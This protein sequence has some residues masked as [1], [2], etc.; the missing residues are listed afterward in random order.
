MDMKK[1]LQAMDG[2]ASKPVEGAD[3]MARFLRMVK[4]AEINQ[5]AAPAP[6][7]PAPQVKV[8]EIPQLPAQDGDQGNGEVVKTNA[9]GTRTYAG[10][11]GTFTYDAQGKAIKYSTPN[12]AGVGQTVDLTNNQTTQNY[13]AGPL[14]TT[15]TTDANG[16]VVSHNTEYDLG[17]GK[18]AMGQDAKGI[19]SK[20][21][22]GRGEEANNIVSNKDLYAMGNKDKEA[23]Y[24][25]AMAQ[26]NGTPVQENSLSK[27]LS[28]VDKNNVSI[29]KEGTNPHKV[30]LPVQM[31]MQHYQQHTEKP[32]PRER[33]IDKYFVEAETEITQ[34]KEEKRALINQYAKT[35]AERVLMK[36]SAQSVSEAPIEMTGDANDPHI[37]GHEKANP[38]SLKGRIMSARAQL[39]ELAELS[40]SDSLLAW[41]Q[42]CK[43][44]KGGMFMGLEQNL[45]QIRHGIEQLAA[46]RKKG[47]VGS[48]GIDRNIGEQGK[49]QFKSAEDNF[50]T[51]TQAPNGTFTIT[52]H[53]PD[54]TLTGTPRQD[55][56]P[57]PHTGIPTYQ[58][59]YDFRKQDFDLATQFYTMPPS[60]KVYD[61][62]IGEG[63][64][65]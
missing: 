20:S 38:M 44:A 27:F 65:K 15:Q 32:Q 31:A 54:I 30:A 10:G 33:L 50:A 19:T 39:Q 58:K 48:R 29:L 6:A 35:I 46:K 4:E 62:N 55:E 26:V 57:Q 40:E 61:E 59:A 45:E 47:G 22:Q 53:D 3:S 11:F 23:T 64:R 49:E 60:I 28:I 37:Y 8:P 43:K 21:W 25:R 56:I 1:I 9:D 17:L 51:I 63:K 52:Y 34:R 18:M 14:N 36:E 7:K 16:N 5:P 2:V 13:N 41:E 42:I 12:F 24:G